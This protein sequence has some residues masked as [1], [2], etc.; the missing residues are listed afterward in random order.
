MRQCVFA[1][2][3]PREAIGIEWRGVEMDVGFRTIQAQHD[4]RVALLVLLAVTSRGRI[5]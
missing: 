5:G 4:S 1:D 3:L 2:E